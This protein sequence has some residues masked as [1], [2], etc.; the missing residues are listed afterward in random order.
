MA[1]PASAPVVSVS[2]DRVGTAPPSAGPKQVKPVGG[3]VNPR[4]VAWISAKPVDRGRKVKLVWWSGVEPCTVLDRVQVR[5]TRSK[6]TITLF[7]GTPAK[8][9]NTACIAIAVQKT[10]TVRLKAPVGRRTLVDG[11]KS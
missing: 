11:A 7:E 6:V 4:K 10:T 1:P 2:T 5:Q 9:K 3:T 8:A